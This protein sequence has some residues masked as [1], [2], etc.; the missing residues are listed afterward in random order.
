MIDL[1]TEAN[2]ETLRKVALLQHSELQRLVLE[3]MKFRREQG[4]SS[5]LN[6]SQLELEIKFLEE[7]LKAREKAIYGASSEKLPRDNQEAEKKEKKVKKGHGPTDQPDLPIEECIHELDEPDKICPSCGGNLEEMEG[8]F[9]ESEEITVVGIVYKKLIHKR[10][11][12][13][14]SCSSCIETALGPLKVIPGGRY[15]T[16]FCSH[17]ALSKYADHIPLSRQVTLMARS[18]LTVTSQTLWDQIE[19]MKDHL[20]PSYEA[21]KK[22]VRSSPVIGADETHWPLL[23]KGKSQKWWSWS[24]CRDDAVFYQILPSRSKEAAKM[25][26]DDYGGI[27]MV[28]GYGVYQSLIKLRPGHPPPRFD[29]AYCWAHVRRKFFEAQADYPVAE[30]MLD[31]IKELYEVESKAKKLDSSDPLKTLLKL[32]ETES[33]LIIKEIKKWIFKQRVLPK[34]SIGKAI[35]YT[36]KLWDGL[37]KFLEDPRIPLDNNG[38]ERSL[39]GQVVGRKNHYGSHSRRGIEVAAIFYSLIETAKL[40]KIDP[41]L[42]LK[43][44]TKRAIL[45]PGTKTLPNDLIKEA[46]EEGMDL[47]DFLQDLDPKNSFCINP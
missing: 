26:L 18:D 43:V 11:K 30:E 45:V 14:C 25:I 17:V 2:I 6:P 44:A 35:K 5:G 16:D 9:E 12:Y 37:L 7:K 15:S 8:Q 33:A 41:G 1:A 34:S 4:E 29:L 31:L 32:R 23:K 39:R 40:A 24:L 20:F 47:K 27:V 21:L 42:Y 19:A 36:K 46:A 22:Y 3:N 28:D 13:R 38:T 10:K